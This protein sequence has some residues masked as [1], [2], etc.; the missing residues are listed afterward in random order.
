MS[1]AGKRMLSALD[2]LR[3]ALKKDEWDERTTA[4]GVVVF[5][6]RI[7]RECVPSGSKLVQDGTQAEHDG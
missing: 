6:P 2:E 7:P 1:K 4:N 3:E 5:T